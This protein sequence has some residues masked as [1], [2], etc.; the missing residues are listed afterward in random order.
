MGNLQERMQADMRTAILEKNEKR[1]DTLRFIVGEFSRVPNLPQDKSV[2]DEQVIKI[3]NK[4]IA[5]EWTLPL[6]DEEFIDILSEYL[7][8]APTDEEVLKW[9]NE[10]IDFSQFKN[11]IQA[12]KPI[13][14]H[15]S[16]AIEGSRVKKL[17]ES[18]E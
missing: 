4:A 10:N 12:M 8:A 7:P 15:F 13:M 6:A 5:S 3:L 18:V 11:R 17:L 9:I 1:K 2:T 14:A 16:G